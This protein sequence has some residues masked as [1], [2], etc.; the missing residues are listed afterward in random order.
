[1]EALTQGLTRG[2]T[3]NPTDNVMRTLWPS[4]KRRLAARFP[5]EEPWT[6]PLYLLRAI[7]LDSA[8]FHL[9][10]TLPPNGAIIAQAF[11]RLPELRQMLAPTFNISFCRMPDDWELEQIRARFGL[12]YSPRVRS[13]DGK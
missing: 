7:P 11:S 3:T 4:F 12:D 5:G 1:M 9:L 13:R 10:A 2:F 8:H 6:R